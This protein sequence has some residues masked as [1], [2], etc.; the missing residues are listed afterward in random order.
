MIENCDSFDVFIGVDVGKEE[1]H[2]GALDRVGKQII[3]KAPL[4]DEAK[5]RDLIGQLK[6][7]GQA[8]FVV[9]QPARIGALPITVTTPPR[10]KRNWQN[11]PSPQ[12]RDRT[13]NLIVSTGLRTGVLQCSCYRRWGV[14]LSLAIP[15]SKRTGTADRKSMLSVQETARKWALPGAA[16]SAEST[17]ANSATTRPAPT[18]KR[19]RSRWRR[20]ATCHNYHLPGKRDTTSWTRDTPARVRDGAH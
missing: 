7:H 3:D 9:D 4:S 18:R 16:T 13:F 12:T 15:G 1:H 17:C 19:I 20:P 2:A 10:H 8:L 5:L 11:P 6:H 14:L